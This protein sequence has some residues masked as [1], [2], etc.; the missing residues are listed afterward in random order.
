[1]YIYVHVH[2]HVGV[3]VVCKD[4]DV[5]VHVHVQSTVHQVWN[6]ILVGAR[7]LFLSKGHFH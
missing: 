3:C 6:F 7:S 2:V 5:H 4:T 1:M